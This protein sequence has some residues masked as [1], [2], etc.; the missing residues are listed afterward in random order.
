MQLSDVID[1]SLVF[2]SYILADL[3]KCEVKVHT[4]TQVIVIGMNPIDKRKCPCEKKNVSAS[5]QEMQIFQHL[6]ARQDF[7]KKRGREF[8]V[9]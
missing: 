6:C 2:P 8:C 3:V 1:N 5:G 9:Y 7:T 4:I